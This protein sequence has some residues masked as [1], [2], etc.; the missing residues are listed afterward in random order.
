MTTRFKEVFP[1]KNTLLAVVH[2]LDVE[3]TIENVKIAVDNG[4]HGAFLINLSMSGRDLLHVFRETRKRLSDV[5]LGINL[6]DFTMNETVRAVGALEKTGQR[7]DG[8]WTDHPEIHGIAPRCNNQ[9][10][11]AEAIRKSGWR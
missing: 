11:I 8:I 3:H 6:L 5:W 9:D 2:S 1:Q 10:V 7:V 4:L